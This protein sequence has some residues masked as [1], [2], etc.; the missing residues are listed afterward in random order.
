MSASLVDGP[1]L[2][3]TTELAISGATPIAASTRLGFMAP[4]RAGA[5]RRHRDPGEVE[6]HELA[7]RCDAGHG[8]SCRWSGCAGAPAAMT[9][10]PCASDLLVEQLSQEAQ[11]GHRVDE[12]S[13][14]Q[15]PR[16]SRARGQVL[17]SA[18]I[19]LL[20][21]AARLQHREIA[22]QQRADAGRP[23]ELV[24]ETAMKSA[25]GSGNLARS[26]RAIG[27]AAASPRSRTICWIV[28]RSA[29]SRRSRC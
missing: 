21:P 1:K 29:G 25:S 3:R 20:L 26:L 18:A 7:A 15:A 23:A 5:P 28:G 17:G 11:P 27:T 6:L 10:P 16:P 4:G 22:D 9:T 19:A 14:R 24:A 8:D 12:G 13:S 2:T